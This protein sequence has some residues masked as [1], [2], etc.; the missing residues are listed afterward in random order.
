MRRQLAV[1][2]IVLL[3]APLAV[4]AAS[5]SVS[6]IRIKL[7]ATHHTDV[8]KVTNK[9][10]ASTLIQAQ[11]A[12]WTQKDGHSSYAATRDLLATPPIFQLTAGGEQVIRIGMRKPPDPNVETAYRLFLTEVPP[13]PTPGHPELHFALRMGIPV[14][15]APS[16]KAP[17]MALQWHENRLSPTKLEVSA[18][19]TGN[20][21][22]Q[23]LKFTLDLPAPQKPI[24]RRAGNYLLPGTT[25]SWTLD[26]PAPISA[27]A[28]LGITA[29]T[30]QGTLHAKL[31]A[32]K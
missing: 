20:V 29:D 23:V 7:S 17:V 10:D 30:D 8:L 32:D 2:L 21:H 1:V 14:F 26:L 27:D 6:P 15:I 13:A 12:V 31:S 25:V 3:V 24:E 11:V 19:N 18:V 28:K 16:A 22:V 4:Q 9:G 5:F